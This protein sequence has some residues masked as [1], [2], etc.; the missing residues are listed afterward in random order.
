MPPPQAA[1]AIGPL[2][3][4]S[5]EGELLLL[6]T[7]LTAGC[8]LMKGAAATVNKM[9]EDIFLN[10]PAIQPTVACIAVSCSSSLLA[11]VA[12]VIVVEAAGMMA[13]AAEAV[14]LVALLLELRY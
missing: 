2:P 5:A 8:R 14:M 6:Q 9:D 10:N 12:A 13:V 4:E 1:P 3:R 11:A 7:R